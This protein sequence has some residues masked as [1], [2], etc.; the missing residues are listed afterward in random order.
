MF[1]PPLYVVTYRPGPEMDRFLTKAL[2]GLLWHILVV[3]EYVVTPN[4]QRLIIKKGIKQ[5]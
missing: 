1:D 2:L 4:L 3:E 5:S